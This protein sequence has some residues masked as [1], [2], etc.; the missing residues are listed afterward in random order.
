MLKFMKKI[1]G[2]LL[3]IPMLISAII[4]TLAPGFFASFG[5]LTEALFTT[6]GANYIVALVCFCSANLLDFKSISKVLRKQGTLLLVKALVAIVFSFAFMQG[7]GL[8]GVWGISAIAFVVAIC[9]L[10][11]SLYLALVTDYGVETDKAAFGLTGILA[12]PAFPIFVFS[13]TQGGGVDWTPIISTLIPI[14]FGIVVANLD[15]DLSK[16]FSSI[17]G[18]L[19]IFMG[20]SFGAGINIIDALKA[21]PQGILLSILFYLIMLPIIYLVETKV[22]KESGISTLGISSIAGLSVSAPSIMAFN[23]PELVPL[24]SVA[25]AQIALGVVI[26]SIITPIITQRLAKSK[27]IEK[28]TLKIIKKKA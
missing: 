25:T 28:N 23:N 3:L 20:W 17:L 14:F 26:T 1:P 24:A 9:S 4:N 7:F 19:M 5:G 21:G 8:Q 13:I 27:G 16:M 10:N 18:V 6:K 15:K 12:V 11:P 22:L 2:G